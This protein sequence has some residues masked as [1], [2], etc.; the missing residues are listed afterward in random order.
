MVP[1]CKEIYH[2]SAI[3]RAEMSK[4]IPKLVPE[5][6][7]IEWGLYALTGIAL[8]VTGCAIFQYIRQRSGQACVSATS[9]G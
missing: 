6:I 4:V 2:P 3:I 5:V 7:H 9:Q 1:V 8:L